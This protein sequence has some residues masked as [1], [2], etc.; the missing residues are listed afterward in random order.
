M[1]QTVSS[2]VLLM[3]SGRGWPLGLV[4]GWLSRA[5]RALLFE[6][7]AQTGPGASSRQRAQTCVRLWATIQLGAFR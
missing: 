5:S 1:R 7:F 4:H 6:E 3:D 2:G